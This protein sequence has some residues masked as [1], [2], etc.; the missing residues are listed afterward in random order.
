MALRYAPLRLAKSIPP[1]DCQFIYRRCARVDGS[2]C[3]VLWL[4]RFASR[5]FPAHVSVCYGSTP[6]NVMERAVIALQTG[7]ADVSFSCF[8]WCACLCFGTASICHFPAWRSRWPQQCSSIRSSTSLL[9][10]AL[11]VGEIF[12][13]SPWR[14]VVLVALTVPI[15]IFKNAVRIAGLSCLGVYVDPEFLHGNLH[16][17]GGLLFSAVGLALLGALLYLLRT[18]PPQRYGRLWHR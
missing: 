16:H 3:P 17:Y 6:V 13:Q 18:A 4:H 7:S 1:A 8:D 12:L 9:L 15:A 2:L 5:R 10:T 14:K 11:V